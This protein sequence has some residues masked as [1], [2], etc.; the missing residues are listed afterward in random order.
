MKTNHLIAVS[1]IEN[2]KLFEF[3]AVISKKLAIFNDFC[4]NTFVYKNAFHIGQG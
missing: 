3:S 2:I 1:N 4:S